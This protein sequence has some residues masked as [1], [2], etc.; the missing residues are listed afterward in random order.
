MSRR[1]KTFLWIICFILCIALF[2]Y[3]LIVLRFREYTDD[4]YVE[5][6]QMFI[7]PLKEG[8]VKAIHTDDT[9]LVEE[10]QLLIELDETDAL[11]ALD[12]AKENL[13]KVVREVCQIF[14]Q[15]F[16]YQAEIEVKKAEYIRT[17]QDYEHRKKV[18]D[19][20]GVSLENYEHAEAFLRG[21]FYSLIMTETLY[22]KSLAMVQATS[23]KSHPLVLSAA[24]NLRNAFVQL[25]RTK[26]YAPA[27]GLCAQRTIQ[28]GMWVKQGEPLLSVIPLN[29]IWVNANFKETQLKRVKMGQKV[30]VFSDLYGDDVVFHGII[31][32]IPGGAGNTFSLLPPQNLSGNWIKIVQRLP[33]R[34]ALD[35]EELKKHPLRLGLS[36]EAYVDLHD[37]KGTLVPTST[38]GSPTYKTSIF[39]QEE[40]GDK[41]MIDLIIKEN[42]DPNLLQYAD[43]PL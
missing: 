20:G 30:R 38:I 33:V 1:S 43:T 12:Q 25:Y 23:I 17:A 35:L 37:Q 39:N 36:M 18:L 28:V 22:E 7:T 26:I 9:F 40:A 27:E 13:A 24:D 2:L 3:W 34:V 10:G 31:Q 8:F 4:A 6:N 41:E 32:G 15:V 42:L 14:Y 19:V 5:G 16:A 29:Q 21:A 11:I